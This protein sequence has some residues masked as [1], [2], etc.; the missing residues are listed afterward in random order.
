EFDFK[1]ERTGIGSDYEVEQDYVEEGHEVLLTIR[2]PSSSILVEIKSTLGDQAR[3]T[4]SQAQIA[5]SNR[6]RFNRCVVR[7]SIGNRTLR[8]RAAQVVKMNAGSMNE[9]HLV[10]GTLV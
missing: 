9:P 1:V 3:M 6:D 10:F 4:V 8:S 5:D 2:T 7:L